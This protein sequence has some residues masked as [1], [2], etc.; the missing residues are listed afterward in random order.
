MYVCRGEGAK[1]WREKHVFWREWWIQVLTLL[2]TDHSL[3]DLSQVPYLLRCLSLAVPLLSSSLGSCA[4][5][6]EGCHTFSSLDLCICSTQ[7]PPPPP[8]FSFLASSPESSFLVCKISI[9]SLFLRKDSPGPTA[10][11][12]VAHDIEGARQLLCLQAPRWQGLCSLITVPSMRQHRV[13][14]K[15]PSEDRLTVWVQVQIPDGTAPHLLLYLCFLIRKI[16]VIIV[17]NLLGDNE[18]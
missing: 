7:K 17:S 14:N 12:Y 13:K 3:C 1:G 11:V 10:E 5:F 4:I 18:D 6:A 2:H 16:K 9:S 8:F 15:V